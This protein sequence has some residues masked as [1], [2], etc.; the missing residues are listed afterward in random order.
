[1]KDRVNSAIRWQIQ[2]VGRRA[3]LGE[4]RKGP[5]EL[6]RQLGAWATGH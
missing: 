2:L 5:E 3:N 1:M 4:D 6:E